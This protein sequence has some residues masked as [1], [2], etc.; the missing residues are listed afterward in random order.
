MG[1]NCKG[2]EP[3]VINPHP[4]PTPT[5]IPVE[6]HFNNIDTIEPINT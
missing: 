4:T 3:I 2:R 5:P 6:D 1:C